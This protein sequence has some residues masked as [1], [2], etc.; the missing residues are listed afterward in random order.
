VDAGPIWKNL[1]L[2]VFTNQLNGCRMAA[3]LPNRLSNLET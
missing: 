2:P 1:L 3:A